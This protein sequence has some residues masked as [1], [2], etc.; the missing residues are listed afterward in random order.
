MHLLGRTTT[1]YAWHIETV[2]KKNDSHFDAALCQYF[3]I[4][5]LQFIFEL[6]FAAGSFGY[7]AAKLGKVCQ[8]KYLVIK[9]DWIRD[10]WY[11]Y[12]FQNAYCIQVLISFPTKI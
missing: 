5:I 8:Y 1:M 3:C 12:K 7:L 9:D 6:L 10:S 2:A 4:I 11:V